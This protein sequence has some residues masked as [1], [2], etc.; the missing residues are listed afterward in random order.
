VSSSPSAPAAGPALATGE[1]AVLQS[2]L[3]R[4]L[5]DLSIALHRYAMY[6]A[7]HPALDP[8][9]QTLARRAD[10][11]LQDRPR[12]AVG[13]ARDRLVI[14]GVVTDERHPLL[15]GLA[16]RLHRHHLAALAF[17][18][19]VTIP[20]LAQV[21]GAIAQ[22]PK[23]GEGPLGARGAGQIPS[24]PHVGL[25]PLTV[26]CLE[27]VGDGATD[28]V[29]AARSAALWVGLAQ[30]ALGH[31]PAVTG[32]AVPTDPDVVA[33]AIDEHQAVE[34]YDQV[35]VGYLQQISEE[36]R[37][38]CTPEVLELRRRV[39]T[40]VSTMRPET[41]QRLLAMGGNGLQRR[42]FVHSAA[43]GMSAAAVVDLV[44]AAAEAS[45]EALSHGLVRLLTKLA[46]HADAGAPV[47]QPLADSALRVQ[48]SRLTCGWELD[49]PNPSDYT[50]MLQ[51]IAQ[52]TTTRAAE[53]ADAR[54]ALADP[55]RLL[56]IC[57][58]LELDGP[59]LW[60]ALAEVVETGELS[61][62]MAFLPERG[63]GGIEDRTW[64]A[65]ASASTVRGLL[66]RE[67]PDFTAL[68]ALL[69]HLHG[70]ALEPLFDLLVDAE[71]RRLRRAV[72]DRLRRT[73]AD[74]AAL[75]LARL[76][77]ERW[78]VV[79]NL[80]ALLAEIEALPSE[81]DPSPWLTHADPRVRRE[82]LRLALRLEHVRDR[83]LAAALEDDDARVLRAALTAA[84]D[85]P[86]PATARRL[87]ELATRDA[88]DDQLRAA[89]VEALVR[90]SRHPQTLDVLMRVA[91]RDGRPGWWPARLAPSQA[92]V[93]AL[94]AL[95]T[96][97]PDEPR[98]AALM[99]RAASS[100]NLEI[101]LA[102]KAAKS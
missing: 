40:L 60:R 25:H 44:K 2:D 95:S 87:A 65:L 77:D 73:G 59:P 70:E 81:C 52:A 29:G 41:L 76:A 102:A 63:R 82:A 54:G 19:G 79:R 78:Y 72:F 3:S 100:A 4:F 17:H 31:D 24:W 66:A 27:I 96:Y 26:G 98:A 6:P 93:A 48:V 36:V 89:A 97:W 28:G 56:H 12:I 46:V 10:A 49:D 68:D 80:L 20:E 18:R 11:L 61:R 14:E 83:A 35:I 67:P 15:R 13:V 39:S 57:L 91:C 21:V 55:V 23:W 85:H 88:L 75:A 47:V 84:P 99:R 62:V 5:V 9:M 1:P 92:V 43:A 74:G 38:S 45:D 64:E 32:P 34:A 86:S 7:G 50:A 42:E 33:R 71:D 22:D 53:Q 101:R 58:E 16:D 90:C 69:P 30:A 94:T 8:V 37:S 51:R